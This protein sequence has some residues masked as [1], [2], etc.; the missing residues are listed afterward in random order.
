[1]QGVAGKKRKQEWCLVIAPAAVES[2]HG[3]EEA[4]GGRAVDGWKR[5]RMADTDDAQE[6]EGVDRD[7]RGNGKKR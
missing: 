6:G 1:L 5:V 7:L 2:D 3:V 4:E